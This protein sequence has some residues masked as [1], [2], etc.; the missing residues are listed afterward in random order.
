MKRSV[1]KLSRPGFTILEFTV[2]LLLFGIAMSALFPLVSTYSRALE[3]LEQR[4]DR[5]QQLSRHRYEDVDGHTYRVDH[6]TEWYQVPASPA[7]PNSGEWVHKWYLVPFSDS[8]SQG[9]DAWARKLGASAT[10][11]YKSPQST[12]EQ[13]PNEP[14]KATDVD[15]CGVDAGTLGYTESGP[16]TDVP[17]SDAYNDG[18]HRSPSGATDV[19]TATWTLPVDP[20][21]WYQ[22]EAT[23]IVLGT[24]PLPLDTYRIVDQDI[25]PATSLTFGPS[26]EWCSLTTKYLSAG[27]VTVQLTTDASGTA[28]ADGMRLVRC[29]VQVESLDPIT[30][31]TATAR[32]SIKPGKRP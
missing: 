1:R 11:K 19:P 24:S 17:D 25:T 29:S 15:P 23:G 2:A 4:P 7:A 20:S 16:W 27:V 6:E 8:D 31:E 3:L 30:A 13:L 26:S 12:T 18:Y 28:I 22:I 5:V 14:T 32:V 21:G 10:I 9:A